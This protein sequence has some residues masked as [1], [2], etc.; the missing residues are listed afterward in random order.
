MKHLSPL[1]YP[2]GKAKLS[3]YISQVIKFNNLTGGTYIEPY[4]GGASIALSLLL[5][6]TVQ[7]IIINDKDRSIYAFWYSVFNHTDNLCQLIED[8]DVC[9]STWQEQRAIQKNKNNA[10]LLSL[11]F[12]TFFLNRTNR[13]GILKAGVIGGLKQQGDYPITARFNKND[14][15]SRIRTIAEHGSDIELHNDD[16]LSLLSHFEQH[17]SPENILIYL[18]PPYY[19]KG[20]NLYMSYYHDSDHRDISNQLSR[21]DSI[22]WLV[23]YDNVPFI[24]DLYHTYRMTEFQLSYCANAPRLGNEVMIYSNNIHIPNIPIY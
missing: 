3:S 4:A 1:R 8:T 22:K 24:K 19:V 12:S 23:T 13:S 18:D 5:N 20:Q 16:A 17:S 6:G 10:D 7:H 2:G 9:I 11:G 21:M 14:L 15:I